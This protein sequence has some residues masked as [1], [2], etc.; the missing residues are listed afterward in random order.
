MTIAVNNEIGN[1]SVSRVL[2]MHSEGKALPPHPEGHD[3]G[4]IYEE[5]TS[6]TPDGKTQRWLYYGGALLGQVPPAREG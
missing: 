1:Q 5:T 2:R 6:E 4:G 3:P